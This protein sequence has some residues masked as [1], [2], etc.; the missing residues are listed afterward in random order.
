MKKQQKKEKLTSCY[1]NEQ[2]LAD[3]KPYS[4]N[5]HKIT[6]IVGVTGPSGS[7]GSSGKTVHVPRSRYA[8]RAHVMGRTI[9]LFILG[10]AALYFFYGMQSSLNFY[11]NVIISIMILIAGGGLCHLFYRYL[12]VKSMYFHA[13]TYPEVQKLKEKGYQRGFHPLFSAT[14]F[15]IVYYFVRM[16]I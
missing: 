11:L 13:A 8:E 14:P 15:G 4:I 1:F 7:I 9:K 2:L 16:I 5:M 12:G 6:G 3:G 10:I